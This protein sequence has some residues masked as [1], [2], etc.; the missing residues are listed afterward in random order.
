M[1]ILRPRARIIR[2]IGDQLISGPEAA[3]IELVK[4]SFDADSPVVNI[5]IIPRG[6]ILPGGEILVS[7]EGH[8]MS[9]AEIIERWFEPATDDKVRRRTSPGGRSMLGAKGIGR[10]AAA[11]LGRF[12]RVESTWQDGN[13]RSLVTVEIDWNWFT[14]DKYLDQINVPV[15]ETKL[16]PKSKFSPGVDLY[17]DDL[18]DPWTE[19]SLESLI[20][21]LRRLVSPV[22]TREEKFSI[23][24]DLTAFTIALHGFDGQELLSRSNLNLE[25]A[26]DSEVDDPFLIRPFGLQEYADYS[27]NGDF[28]KEGSFTGTFVIQR[29]DAHPQSLTVQAPVIKP[30]EQSC[31]DFHVRIN[32]YD[33]ETDALQGLFA[34][35]GLDLGRIGVLNARRILTEN[36]GIAIFRKDFRIRPYGEPENDW[37]ELEGQRVQDPSRRLGLS[38]VS[39]FVQVEDEQSSGLIER[40]SREGL[41]HN[42]SFARLKMLIQNVLLHAEELRFDFRRKAGLSRALPG[43]LENLRA[44]ASLRRVAHVAKSLPQVY[45]EKVE[46]AIDQ[47]SAELAEELK[48][49]DQYQQVLQSRAALGLVLAEVVHEGRRFLN[50]VASSA[51]AILDGK[52][53]LVEE[54]E[55]GEVYRRQFPENAQTVHD[56]VR[57]L[58]RLFKKLDPISGRKRGRAGKLPVCQIVTRALDLFQDV[59]LEAAVVVSVD[60][61][62]TLVAHGYEEDLQAA[63]MNIVDNGLYWL[64]TCDHPRKM[65]IA[66]NTRPKEI[67]ISISN[68]GPVISPPYTERLFEAGFTLKSSGTGLGLAISRE[69]MRRSKGDVSFDSDSPETRFVIRIPRV[70]N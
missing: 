25:D 14:A 61:D 69:A 70:E 63:L 60:C 51:K 41:E 40:S 50:P 35:M 10:F 30:D 13:S 31:G 42:A 2:T 67:L 46:A 62:D 23:R 59:I 57:D 65:S 5:K 4:N 9:K 12:T 17:I 38:Q 8:G 18:R 52:D 43:N 6:T 26:P 29:G 45:R 44:A 33:R 47:D 54:S 49:I 20:R 32:I 37:L 19:K 68:N 22:K 39:G 58:S 3:L 34:R 66:V 48:Q 24:L 55:R 64:A 1:A 36:S 53:W 11:R 28:D 7:D 27:L 15:E 21:E 16:P 56:G